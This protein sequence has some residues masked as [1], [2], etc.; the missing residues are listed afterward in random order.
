RH[1]SDSVWTVD[2]VD[3]S[4]IQKTGELFYGNTYFGSLG[5]QMCMLSLCRSSASSQRSFR[6]S[7]V[8]QSLAI[9][10]LHL[11]QQPSP[12]YRSRSRPTTSTAPARF[13]CRSSP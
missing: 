13:F 5:T 11:L 4:L 8:S 1:C 2:L 6:Y 12:H 10:L 7:H 9:N 3:T